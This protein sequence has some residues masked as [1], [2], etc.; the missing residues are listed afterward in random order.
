VVED[1]CG[2]L[3]IDTAVCADFRYAIENKT[4]QYKNKQ[5]QRAALSVNRRSERFFAE[6][7]GLKRVLRGAYY[8]V[9][10]ENAP[11]RLDPADRERLAEFYAPHNARFAVLLADAGTVDV[12]AW[13]DV[14]RRV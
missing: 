11:E 8:R 1:L 9:N 13:L 7:A 12:P 5:L 2:W 10:S 6:H 4:V 3:G 14:H